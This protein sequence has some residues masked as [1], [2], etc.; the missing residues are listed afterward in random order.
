MADNESV[1][2]AVAAAI[3]ESLRDYDEVKLAVVTGEQIGPLGGSSN[4][5]LVAFKTEMGLVGGVV[6]VYFDNS[7]H[8]QLVDSLDQIE[9][10][11]DLEKRV[12]ALAKKLS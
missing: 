9:A 7:T 11:A 2:Q 5:V 4:R 8:R 10:N 1:R 12:K 6:N 3:A